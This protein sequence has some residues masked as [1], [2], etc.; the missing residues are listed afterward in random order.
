MKYRAR[1]IIVPTSNLASN[2]ALSFTPKAARST[3]WAKNVVII[4]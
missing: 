3:D 1:E 2:L 4:T